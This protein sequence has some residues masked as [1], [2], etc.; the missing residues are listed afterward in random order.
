[1]APY[2]IAIV[3]LVLCSI[4]FSATE[5]AFTSFNRIKM[6]NMA[7]D[8]VRNADLVLKIAEK[9]DNLI[10]T[11]LIGNNIANISISTVSTVLCIMI[12]GAKHGPTIATAGV[13]II[14]L[15]FGEISPKIIAREKPEQVALLAAPVIKGIIVALKP[16]TICFN[17]LQRILYRIIGVNDEPEFSE[18]ELLTIVEEAEAGGAIG[19][20]QSELISN[21]IEFKDIEAIDIITPRVDII[22]VEK[23]D[24]LEEIRDTFRES[25]LSR[26]PVYEDDLDNIVGVINQKDFYNSDLVNDEDVNGIIKPVT[27]VAESIKA[28]VLLKKMQL[29]KTHIAIVV[30]EYG[31]TTGLVTMEDIIEEIVGEIYD[32]HDAIELRDVKPL[33]NDTFTVAGGANL[34][35]FFEIFGE[36]VEC[37]ATTINGWVMIE[38]D[39]LPKK[40]DRFVYLSKHKQFSVTVSKADSR[41]ALMTYIKVEARPEEDD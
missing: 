15:I 22:A 6:K 41:R 1:M 28:S 19:E 21:A 14:V 13:T 32:E 26:V 40:G 37:D 3:A 31:G 12:W 4:F 24:S 17:G 25:G 20:E 29:M 18:D 8:D 23:G 38:L 7:S 5:T 33:G 2:I 27:Y 9:Y 30:D 11:I 39:R 10:T 35:K 36:E 34:E 16:I